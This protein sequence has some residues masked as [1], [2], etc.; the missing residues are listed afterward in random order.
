MR[1][2]RRVLLAAAAGVTAMALGGC[3]TS[4]RS[5]Y[6]RQLNH[7]VADEPVAHEDVAFAFG[8]DDYAPNRPSV[9]VLRGNEAVDEN[10]Q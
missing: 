9:T 8:L 5:V 7:S 2:Q 3:V 1:T 10:D 4:Q 6:Q